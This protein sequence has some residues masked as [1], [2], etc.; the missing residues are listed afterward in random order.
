VGHCVSRHG[1]DRDDDV[2]DCNRNAEQRCDQPTAQRIHALQREQH[3]GKWP[4]PGNRLNRTAIENR[5]RCV[6]DYQAGEEK[7]AGER[8]DGR[9]RARRAPKL[10]NTPGDENVPHD[11]DRHHRHVEDGEECGPGS[12]RLTRPEPRAHAMRWQAH[13][14]ASSFR[15]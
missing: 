14:A 8:R 10:S 12:A 4:H 1:D 5:S 15:G 9:E 3:G 11:D 6:G 13:Q 2:V 7:Q